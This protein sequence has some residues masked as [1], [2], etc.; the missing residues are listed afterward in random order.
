[1][2]SQALPFGFIPRKAKPGPATSS[3]FIRDSVYG[4]PREKAGPLS[5]AAVTAEYVSRSFLSID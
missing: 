5:A 2:L 1:M 4:A 3:S